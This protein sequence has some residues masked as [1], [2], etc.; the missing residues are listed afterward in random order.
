[1]AWI[2]PR[3]RMAKWCMVLAALTSGGVSLAMANPAAAPWFD[4]T[5]QPT[6][7]AHQAVDLLADAAAHGLDPQDYQ[8][9]ALRA[10]LHAPAGTSP[11]AEPPPSQTALAHALTAQWLH[12]VRDL[13]GGRVD[14]RRLYQ[15]VYAVPGSPFDAEALLRQAIDRGD[16]AWA[17]RQAQPR[18]SQYD[19]LRAYL[20]RYRERVGH[21]AWAQPLP[22]VA[23]GRKAHVLQPGD[24]FAGASALA[25]RL[26]ALG[27]LPEPWTSDALAPSVSLRYAGVLVDAVRHF[28]ARHGL[29]VDGIV[30]PATWAQLAV[31]PAQRV[32][33][34]VVNLERLRWTPAVRADR[35]VVVN[36]P[37]FMLRAYEHD[38]SGVRVALESRVVVGKSLDTRTPLMQ[39]ALQAI[40]FQPYWNIPPSIAHLE[41][42]P[43]LRRDPGYLQRLGLEFV[44]PNGRVSQ[45]VTPERLDGVLAGQWRLR[46]RPGPLNALGAI[47]FVFP[48]RE[49]IYLHHTPEPS[50]FERT[51]RD[52]SH[53]CVRVEQVA[54]LAEFV[55]AP[56]SGWSRDRIDAALTSERPQTVRLAQ[57]VPVVLGYGTAVAKQGQIHFYDD[58]YGHDAALAAALLLRPPT[59]AWPLE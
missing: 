22:P 46:Q 21:P 25:Q 14:P 5:G 57:P 52:F 59:T 43:R 54:A 19:R 17:V 13:H 34:I 7:L 33:Q 20:S 24:T 36:V 32:Q 49:H 42:V 1:M 39:E 27:D 45:E 12:F 2:V 38:A 10:R 4:A 30:G 6:T 15:G 8:A 56:M 29:R 55:L 31:T 26:H 35:L 50:L 37:E 40:E 51:R 41:T 16:L 23:S 11:S 47:K 53:G 48:N 28:Q 3:I 58:I 9:P 44:S 18:F